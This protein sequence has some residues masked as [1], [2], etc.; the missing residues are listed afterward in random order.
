MTRAGK[1][2]FYFGFWVLACGLGLFLLPEL[3]LKLVGMTLP[4]YVTVRLFGM[5][6]VYLSIYY[7]VAGRYPA[8]WPFFRMTV[9]TR[10]SA[11][12]VVCVLVLLG[13][14]KPLIIGFVVVDALGALWTYLAL[15]RDRAEGLLT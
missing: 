4:D 6:L 7:L 5:V 12:L 15:R 3:C 8:F 11:L 1:S 9:Y 10:A 2:I 14:A 13:I